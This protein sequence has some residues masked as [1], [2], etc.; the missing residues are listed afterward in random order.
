MEESESIA[1]S[2]LVHYM[3]QATVRKIANYHGRQI[4]VQ[5]E[6]RCKKKMMLLD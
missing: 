6:K 3:F 2:F 4:T 1:I 5:E